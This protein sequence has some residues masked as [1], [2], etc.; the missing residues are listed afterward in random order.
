MDKSSPSIYE[1][2]R[3]LVRV[4][5]W[6]KQMFSELG[7]IVSDEDIDRAKDK[8]SMVVE[9]WVENAHKKGSLIVQSNFHY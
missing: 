2:L 1:L 9:K 3:I 8:I 7:L 6:N 4:S 5:G